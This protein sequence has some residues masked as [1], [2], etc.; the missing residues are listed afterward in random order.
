M[1]VLKKIYLLYKK[2]GN[3]TKILDLYP[4]YNQ[5]KNFMSTVEIVDIIF[6]DIEY[7]E[8]IIKFEPYNA[9]QIPAEFKQSI[10]N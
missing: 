5:S 6:Q 7:T 4:E 3:F 2:I 9:Y 1:K 8:G 10:P